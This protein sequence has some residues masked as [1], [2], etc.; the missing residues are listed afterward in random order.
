M[1]IRTLGLVTFTGAAQP[2]LGDVTT[3]AVNAP[4]DG[5]DVSITVASNVLYQV[6]DRIVLE[7]RTVNQDDYTITKFTTNLNAASTTVIQAH[8]DGGAGVAHVSGVILQLQIP[9]IDLVVKPI[10]GGA[11]NVFIGSD[12]TVT[13]VPAGSVC[14]EIEKTASGTGTTAWHMAGGTGANIE[15]TGDAWMIGTAGDKTTSYA[16]VL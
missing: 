16:L 7:P 6:G 13:A 11:G 8:W 9:C 15:N 4:L 10:S 2:V 3:A 1:A 12:N 14:Y 5:Q